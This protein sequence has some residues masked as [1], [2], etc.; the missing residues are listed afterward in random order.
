VGY[1]Q[2]CKFGFPNNFNQFVM[3]GT[4]PDM[5]ANMDEFNRSSDVSLALGFSFDVTPVADQV[6]ACTNI[7]S[8]YSF[9][10]LTG[11]LDPATAL[12]EFQQKL[13]DAGINDIIA[14]KQA[15]LDAWVAAN[16]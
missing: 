16:G 11:Q 8:E 13:I 10:L 6:A 3:E 9:P 4:D 12:P 1:L 5:W 14:E 2:F 7:V 15:Q